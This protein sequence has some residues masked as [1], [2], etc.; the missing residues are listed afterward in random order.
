MNEKRGKSGSL[1]TSSAT[2][3]SRADLRVLQF[4]GKKR[5]PRF[6]SAAGENDFEKRLLRKAD[7]RA[8]GKDVR[9]EKGARDAVLLHPLKGKAFYAPLWEVPLPLGRQS[10]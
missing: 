7:A 4:I 1:N 5:V 8:V 6:G 9:R 2:D 3:V 10:G